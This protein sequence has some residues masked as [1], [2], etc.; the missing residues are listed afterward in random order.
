MEQKKLKL[1]IIVSI[2]VVVVFFLA[3]FL[4]TI[5]RQGRFYRHRLGLDQKSKPTE[6][7]D[8][9]SKYRL[10]DEPDPDNSD[11]DPHDQS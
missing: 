2:V 4:L 1:L 8:L 3:I 5:F 10:D 11:K 6:Y 7:V 9:W